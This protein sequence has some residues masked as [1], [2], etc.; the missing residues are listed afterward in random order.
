MSQVSLNTNAL[1]RPDPALRSGAAF[2]SRRTD[3][4]NPGRAQD[5][6]ELSDAARQASIDS[7]SVRLH[8]VQS[9]RERVAAGTYETPDKVAIAAH[10]FARALRAGA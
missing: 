8:L 6:V 9:V 10:E 7:G 5:R 2:G 3:E 4:P 1:T